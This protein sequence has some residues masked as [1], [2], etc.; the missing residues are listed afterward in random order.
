MNRMDLANPWKTYAEWSKI[1]GPI[2]KI[3]LMGSE[4][5]VVS[6]EKI[7]LE[8]LDRRSSKYS[9]RMWFATAEPCIGIVRTFLP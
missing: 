3:T 7:A 2:F 4:T 8:L 5:V 9:G 6:D 1:H